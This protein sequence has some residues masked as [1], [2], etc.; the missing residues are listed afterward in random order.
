MLNPKNIPIPNPDILGRVVDN[1]AVLV[2]PELGKVKVIN[3]VGAAIWQ[4][5]DGKRNIQQIS[6]EICEQFEIDPTTAEADTL[7]F[8]ASLNERQ[9]VAIE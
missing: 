1:E 6:A 9:I 7:R 4:L 2:L 8:I 5:I 3:E